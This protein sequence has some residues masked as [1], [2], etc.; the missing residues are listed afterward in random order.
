METTSHIDQLRAAMHQAGLPM[1]AI[2]PGANLRYL[3]G[4][5]KHASER[6]ALLFVPRS[7]PLRMVLP[8]LEQPRAASEAQSPIVFYAWQD[9]QGYAAALQSCV[10][11]LDLGDQLGVEYGAMRLLEL[12]A[13]EAVA[14][15]TTEDA[16]ELLAGLRMR[17][18]AAELRAMRAAV[19]A[20]EQGLQ[21]AIDAIVP[22]VSEREVAEVWERAMREAGGDEPSFTTI[23]ASGPNSANPHH[24]TGDRQMR[25]GD[26]IILDGGAR[27]GGRVGQACRRQSVRRADH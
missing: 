23:V 10:D 7:G 25:P 20:V 14:T 15:I 11:E 17:K 6:L 26:L 24:T 8:A 22:G 21:A 2:V 18:D 12:R 5:T 13:I 27:V 19:A 9:D 4:L 1:L 16:S 3:Q